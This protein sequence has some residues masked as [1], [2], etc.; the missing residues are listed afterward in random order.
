VQ[1]IVDRGFNRKTAYQIVKEA[2]RRAEAGLDT[3]KQ[4]GA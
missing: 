4:Q 3:T 2:Y 1:A